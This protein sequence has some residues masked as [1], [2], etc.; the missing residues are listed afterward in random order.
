MWQL[1]T[2]NK[3]IGHLTERFEMY[4]ISYSY[5]Q[6]KTFKNSYVKYALIL[7]YVWVKEPIAV[8]IPWWCFSCINV[9][10]T[11]VW[12]ADVDEC[13]KRNG[14][15]DHKCNNT[16]GSYRCSC[17]QGYMLVGRHMCN[18]K[19][20]ILDAYNVTTGI[21]YTKHK[22]HFVFLSL[23]VKIFKSSS[24]NDIFYFSC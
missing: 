2:S 13:S 9:G 4:Q 20:Q 3:C 1:L 14:G 5:S 12:F 11:T 19:P 23:Q 10:C 18:G 16:M 22:Q 8:H 7:V 6:I 24:N 15:C 21:M 17:H